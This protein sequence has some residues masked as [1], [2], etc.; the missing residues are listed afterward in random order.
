MPKPID[1][2][3]E[4]WGPRLLILGHY[5]QADEVLQYA[6]I[7]GDSLELARR[8][9][10]SKEAERIVLCGVMFMAESADL[11]SAPEQT[12]YMPDVTASCPMA[13]MAWP[14][15]VRQAWTCLT[16]VAPD[17]VPVVYVN[18]TAAVK[19][20]C[21]EHGGLTCTSASAPAV[22]KWAFDQGKKVFFLPD[23][24]LGT[25][26]A[27]DLGLPEEAIAI[28]DPA[29]VNGGLSS[30]TIARARMVVWKGFC[31]VHSRFSVQDVAEARKRYPGARVVVHPEAPRAVVRLCDAHGSTSQLIREV[32]DAP[33]GSTIVVG[34][35]VTLVRRLAQRHAGRVAV[36]PLKESTCLNMAMTTEEKLLR[37]LQ[38][39]PARNEVQVP[40]ALRASAR[41][42]LSRMLAL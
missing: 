18:S 7:V 3:R 8:A 17:W 16:A 22:L 35:E 5:Y 24:H 40:D 27:F 25:N 21:G 38:E 11:L 39:W 1:D 29:L 36:Y 32:E 4:K 33:S 34:T 19:A 41:A 23:E 12:V 28:Y 31:Y 10:A 13:L 26:T 6:D 15:G 2:I 9:A 30:D 37:L 14:D 20:F 42:A